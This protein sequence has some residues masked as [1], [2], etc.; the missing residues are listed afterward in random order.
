MRRNM[1]SFHK[2]MK[3]W[4][5]TDPAMTAGF[6]L[7]LI[8]EEQVGGSAS[9]A[10]VAWRH[11]DYCSVC[12]IPVALS[13]SDLGSESAA[14]PTSPHVHKGQRSTGPMLSCSPHRVLDNEIKARGEGPDS[15]WQCSLCPVKRNVEVEARMKRGEHR[16]KDRTI[17]AGRDAFCSAR[18]GRYSF[19][20][21]F[22]RRIRPNGMP[23]RRSHGLC[24][25]VLAAALAAYA[26]K[27]CQFTQTPN[28]D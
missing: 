11:A 23:Q 24:T 12:S 21:R 13:A 18:V 19:R 28:P 9:A 15:L 3:A 27:S 17:D 1:C 26:R 6:L 22:F 7:E 20:V 25:L 16:R 5:A 14:W 2:V 10:V 4:E 8:R